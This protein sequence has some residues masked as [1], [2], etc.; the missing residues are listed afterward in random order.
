M[1]RAAAQE[2]PKGAAARRQFNDAL[3]SLGLRPHGAELRRGGTAQDQ[4]E[5]LR[6]AGRFA[7][8]P[9]WAEQFRAYTRGVA[10]GQRKKANE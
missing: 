8:P 9:E 3:R 1:K 4:P 5:N 2:G 6:D 10:G 7:P